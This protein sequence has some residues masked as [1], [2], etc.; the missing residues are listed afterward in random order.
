[1]DKSSSERKLVHILQLA[2]SGELAAAY[3]YRGHWKS[4]GN[5]EERDRIRSIE[6]EE[7]HHRKLVGGSL[8]SVGGRPGKWKEIQASVIGRTVGLLCRAAG[9]L[10]PMYGAGKLESR[11]IKEYEAAARHARDCGHSEFI[12][13]LLGMAEVEWEHEKF[14][15]SQVLK[16]KWGCRLPIWQSPPPKESIRASFTKASVEQSVRRLFNG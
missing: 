4:V 11:N 15:R 13:C 5:L 2:Y 1:M 12:D 3:A 16:H 9:W 7:W 6:E 10:A 14:F 8:Q